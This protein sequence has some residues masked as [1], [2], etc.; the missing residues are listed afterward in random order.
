MALFYGGELADG[1]VQGRVVSIGV[2]VVL[3]DF[4]GDGGGVE[5]LLAAKHLEVV[6]EQKEGAL[7][8]HLLLLQRA[9]LVVGRQPSCRNLRQPVRQGGRQGG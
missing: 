7:V 8:G 3:L 2:G 9:H 1:G 5:A 4:E 6:P